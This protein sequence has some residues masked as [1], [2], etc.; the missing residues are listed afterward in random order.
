[1]YLL[2]LWLPMK[3][4]ALHWEQFSDSPKLTKNAIFCMIRTNTC[5]RALG[6][7]ALTQ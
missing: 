6:K 4:L 5:I 1:M 3:E 7:L 2:Q